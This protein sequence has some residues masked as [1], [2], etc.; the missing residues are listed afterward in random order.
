[1]IPGIG[2]TT[3]DTTPGPT[4]TH[5]IRGGA[6]HTT[7]QSTLDGGHRFMINGTGDIPSMDGVVAECIMAGHTAMAQP[8][9]SVLHE[10]RARPEVAA[11]E[12][13]T[14]RVEGACRQVTRV[15][16]HGAPILQDNH[17]LVPGF[18]R[19]EAEVTAK[20]GVP[21]AQSK[22]RR[23]VVAGRAP[24]ANVQAEKYASLPGHLLIHLPRAVRGARHDPAVRLKAN[25][26]AVAVD[27]MA[28]DPIHRRHPQLLR[29]PVPR[30]VL[31][32]RETEAGE[33]PAGETA[34]SN[35]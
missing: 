22:E 5:I 9:T 35:C 8:G 4:T 30:Q 34:V 1:M 18:H 16:E 28:E 24:Q 21:E 11:A 15:V 31:L 19:D 7:R 20:G 29:R 27:L 2:A 32:H 33:V 6:E 14:M 13:R 12:L 25:P 23:L 26:E 3:G 10:R 17:L